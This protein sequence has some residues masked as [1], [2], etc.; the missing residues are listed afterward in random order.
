M[1]PSG[2]RARVYVPQTKDETKD[3][4]TGKRR[5]SLAQSQADVDAGRPQVQAFSMR[6]GGEARGGAAAEGDAGAMAALRAYPKEG[7]FASGLRSVSAWCRLCYPPTHSHCV[8]LVRS[9]RIGA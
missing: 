7:K 8:S 6:A 5:A 9:D 3:E 2:V 1:P 4:T